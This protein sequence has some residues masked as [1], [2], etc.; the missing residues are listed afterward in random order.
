MGEN[1]NINIIVRDMKNP[2]VLDKI[3]LIND[4]SGQTVPPIPGQSV[5][6]FLG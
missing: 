3:N 6:P 5:P 4:Y 2:Y 1:C